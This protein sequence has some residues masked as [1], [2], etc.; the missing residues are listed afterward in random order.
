MK[1]LRDAI[2]LL[3]LC[4]PQLRAGTGT[5]ALPFLKLAQGARPA[6]MG[7]AYC[8]AGDDVWSV[9]YNP[10]GAALAQRQEIALA[11]NEW[12]E[13]MRN[14]SAVYE[15]PS[16]PDATL[17]AGLNALFSGAMDKLDV[18]GAETGS[19]S[20]QEGALSLGAATAL[21]SG[22]YGGAALKGLYQRTTVGSAYAWAGDAGLLKV[23]GDWRFGLSAANFGTRL[24]LGSTAFP[25]PLVLRGGIAWNYMQRLTI[26]A[27]GVKAGESAAAP[28]VGA[29]GQIPTGPDGAFYVRAGYTGGRSR[30][31]GSGVTAGLGLRNGDLSVDYAYA[32]YGELGDAHR[33]TIAV[34]FGGERQKAQKRRY[35]APQRKVVRP[36]PAA[37]NGEPAKAEPAKRKAAAGNGSGKDVYFMW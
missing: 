17:F 7:G 32:P 34:R 23:E 4:A 18:S 36:A 27:D 22:Y 10:A 28:A 9:F 31:T 24:K 6:A 37:D 21:G 2:L 20:S 19:F 13:G 29:E 26:T 14:E 11:H 30:F 33:I 35:A 15:G 16:G 12:L 8:A 25:L 3:C 1:K 5:T